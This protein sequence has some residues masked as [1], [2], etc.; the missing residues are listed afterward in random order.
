MTVKLRR[1]VENLQGQVNNL[2]N[3][4]GASKGSG[5][6]ENKPSESGPRMPKELL[7]LESFIEKKGVKTPICWKFHMDCCEGAEPGGRCGEGLHVCIKVAVPLIRRGT[8]D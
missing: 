3:A 4:E 1:T 2:K 8:T 6:Q 5:K 7:G